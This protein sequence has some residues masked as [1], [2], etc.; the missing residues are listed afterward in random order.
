MAETLETIRQQVAKLVGR[1]VEEAA[2]LVWPESGD[3]ETDTQLHLR[4]D[5]DEEITVRTDPDGQTPCLEHER[6]E[7]K[8]TWSELPQR[9]AE[10]QQPGFWNNDREHGYEVFRVDDTSE[11]SILQSATIS[12]A[13]IV[14]VGADDDLAPIGIRFDLDNGGTVYSAA[15]T[16]GNVLLREA[17]RYD[18]DD[19]QTEVAVLPQ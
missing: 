4:L 19:R 8:Y 11:L 6:V 16:Y 5:G 17:P 18:F 3:E 15:G 13:A 2:L 12:N 1:R 9:R 10:W 7:V 14:C